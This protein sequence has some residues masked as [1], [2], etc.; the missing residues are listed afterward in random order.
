MSYAPNRAT[1]NGCVKTDDHEVMGTIPVANPTS[2]YSVSDV[3]RSVV[4]PVCKLVNIWIEGTKKR[5][6]DTGNEHR[7]SVKL[8]EEAI[9]FVRYQIA[10]Q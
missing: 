6:W 8:T 10:V 1:A 4:L 5:E 7:I 2:D 9:N 3:S